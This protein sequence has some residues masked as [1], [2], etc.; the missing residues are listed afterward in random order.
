MGHA[1]IASQIEWKVT[2]SKP[3]CVV[4]SMVSEHNQPSIWRFRR[5]S[6]G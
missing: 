1:Q 5:Q 4:A 3:G 6:P 2:V